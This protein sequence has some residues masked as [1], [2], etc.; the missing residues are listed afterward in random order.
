MRPVEILNFLYGNGYSRVRRPVLRGDVYVIVATDAR[1]LR[2]RLVIDAFDGYLVNREVLG[3]DPS[4]AR[5]ERRR[6]NALLAEDGASLDAIA[7]DSSVTIDGTPKAKP[8]PKPKRPKVA[9]LPPS[10]EGDLSAPGAAR[11]KAPPVEPET[12]APAVEPSGLPQ[13]GLARP[14]ATASPPK[15]KVKSPEAATVLTTPEP[16]RPIGPAKP[17]APRLVAPDDK[18]VVATAAPVPVSRPKPRI[19]PITPP[20][21]LDAPKLPPPPPLR[22]GPPIP[23][24]VGFD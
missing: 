23:P 22:S 11:P 24:V 14:P 21:E 18:P 6:G 9:V 10:D 20:A 17:A 3:R 16:K 13:T 4:Y 12:A 19:I 2:V 5:N 15:E 1:G 7:P 8:K